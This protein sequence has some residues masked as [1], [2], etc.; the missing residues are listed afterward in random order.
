MCLGKPSRKLID[1]SSKRLTI[2]AFDFPWLKH[3]S[4]LLSIIAL[5]VLFPIPASAQ[6]DQG[7]I[8]GTITDTNGGL[9]PGASV[10]VKNERTGEERT[11]T[12]NETGYFIISALRPASYSV[13]ASAQNLSAQATNVQ[14]LVGQ[15]L[16]LPLIVQPTGSP[17]LHLPTAKQAYRLQAQYRHN[18]QCG[19]SADSV[20]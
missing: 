15:E 12:T 6:T 13:T 2:R 1:S 20:S 18:G 4:I 7:R 3:T 16:N 19:L 10:V 5:V 11:A 8:V 9:V 17:C 14:V